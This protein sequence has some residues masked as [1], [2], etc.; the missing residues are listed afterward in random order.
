MNRAAAQSSCSSHIQRPISDS[1]TQ[2]TMSGVTRNAK[3]L[4]TSIIDLMRGCEVS[5]D[6]IDDMTPKLVDL[7]ED[8]TVRMDKVDKE[9]NTQKEL[10]TTLIQ[11]IGSLER[12]LKKTVAAERRRDFNLVRNNVICKTRKNIGDVQKFVVSTVELGGGGKTA[13]KNIPVVEIPVKQR[14]AEGGKQKD[15]KVYRVALGDGQKKALFAGLVKANLAGDEND[16]R[17]DNECPAFLVNTKRQM[18]RISYTLRSK[19]KESHKIKVKVALAGLKMRIRIKDKGNSAWINL[20][21]AKC[22]HYLDSKVFYAPDEV[23]AAGIPT[24]AEF[25]KRTLEALD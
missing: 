13:Q 12:Q 2:I 19:F 10:I 7:V 8:F 3:V 25:Y 1:F 15:T 24:V 4:V 21:D 18:E 20:D 9:L 16:L 5:Q 23:P 11:R 22:A 17:L 6:K 14:E